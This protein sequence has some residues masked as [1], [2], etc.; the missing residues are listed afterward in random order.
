MRA[1][2]RWGGLGCASSSA[3]A[4][5]GLRSA[6]THRRAWIWARGRLGEGAGLSKFA[7]GNLE[8]PWGLLIM[9]ARPKW[10]GERTDRTE[11]PNSLLW[12][13]P[14]RA[15]SLPAWARSMWSSHCVC[16]LPNSTNLRSLRPSARARASSHPRSP[17]QRSSRASSACKRFSISA[18]ERSAPAPQRTRR[19]PSGSPCPARHRR[20]P[21]WAPPSARPA[22]AGP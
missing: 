12:A 11:E 17:L 19:R 15:R 4:Q 3:S 14:R 5:L 9:L 20:G 13:T 7:K 22:V 18:Q 6:S 2:Q 1:G 8:A 10:G 21:C 16:R